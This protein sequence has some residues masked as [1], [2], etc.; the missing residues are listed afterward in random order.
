MLAVSPVHTIYWEESGNPNGKPVVIVH[1][2][3]GGGSSPAN[4]RFFDPKS[5]RII[6]F[7][8]R[9][10]GKSLPHACLED[11]TTWHLVDDI[12]TLR[13]ELGIE[14]WQVFG[15]S[16]GST[17]ALT[18]AIKHPERVTELILRGIFML[19]PQELQWYY[20]E[21]ASKIFPDHWA[22]YRDHIPPEERGNFIEA[23]HRRLTSDDEQV[24]LA[25]ATCWSTWEQKTSA[26]LPD[27]VAAAKGEDA[28]FALAFARI[29]NHFFLNKGWFPTD[30]WILDNVDA[31]RHIPTV[32]VQGR[33]DVVCPMQTA[34]D[35]HQA[36]PE[37]RFVIL[38]DS[39]HT[40][41]EPGTATAALQATDGFRPPVAPGAQ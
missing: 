9:G 7:D 37:A 20:Q 2:G 22:A 21:G 13:N 6:Q 8:Q 23:Y 14:R 36:F 41:R 31:V 26:L 30:S 40:L 11:N 28:H 32:I 24:R 38:E 1:G 27:P 5:Y 3:P 16:W 17:L 12:E 39:G 25:A 33:Y 10:C 15:G 18:Y 4:R 29:E 19:R 34:W 35:L